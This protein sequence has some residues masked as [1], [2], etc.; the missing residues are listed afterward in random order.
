LPRKNHVYKTTNESFRFHN[1]KI[2][3]MRC[4]LDFTENP[5]LFEK[6]PTSPS[7]LAT[8]IC[9]FSAGTTRPTQSIIFVPLLLSLLFLSLY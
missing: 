7:G 1:K 8:P 5:R 6:F 2:D 9:P 4:K 3:G